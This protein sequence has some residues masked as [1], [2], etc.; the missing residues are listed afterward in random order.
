MVS[1]FACDFVQNLT[2]FVLT[3]YSSALIACSGD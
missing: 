1:S 3:I 2:I